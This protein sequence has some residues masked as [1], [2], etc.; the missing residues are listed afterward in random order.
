MILEIVANAVR[1]GGEMESN[2]VGN[3][4]VNCLFWQVVISY[5]EKNH[6]RIHWKTCINIAA[7]VRGL[8]S[9]SSTPIFM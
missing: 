3:V 4:G 5:S 8:H 2:V 9:F 7:P 1:Q 6:K